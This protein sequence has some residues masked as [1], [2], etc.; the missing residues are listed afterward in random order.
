M[1][2]T[3]LILI[4]ALGLWG[5]END[6]S[7]NLD[8]PSVPLIYA[9]FNGSD[10]S[11]FIRVSKS[12][13]TNENVLNRSINSDSL[14]YQDVH[15]TL[16]RWAFGNFVQDVQFELSNGH[17]RQ[18]GIFPESEIPL[19]ELKKN[20]ESISFFETH[21]IDLFR[22]IIDIPN[23]PIVFSEFEI[24]MPIQ[25]LI[26]R[27]NG[28]AYNMFNFK[29]IFFTSANYNE[30]FVRIHYINRY[31]DSTSQET[32]IWKEF[33]EHINSHDYKTKEYK[34]A[35]EGIPLFDRIG[36]VIPND[37]RVSNRKF[38]YAE[39]IYYCSDENLYQYNESLTAVPSDQAGKYFSNV[40]N[41]MGI[42]GSTYTTSRTILF[43]YRSLD[44]L[45]NGEFTKHLKFK[46]W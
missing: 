42:V 35:I 13:Q 17:K 21:S 1:R 11:H 26:P 14:E 31:P 20:R 15:I 29:T 33:H 23:K 24:L 25:T 12:F 4:L 39:I 18:P 30:V 3:L 36:K 16:E 44:E 6:F 37:S 8:A 32:A 5:C 34:V 40:V 38:E 2:A 19:Y 43:D 41:G 10:S 9:V 22:L 28:R 46:M 45:C 7:P 27:L